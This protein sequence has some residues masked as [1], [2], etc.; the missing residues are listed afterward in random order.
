M[1]EKLQ[2]DQT[3]IM[4]K[5]SIRKKELVLLAAHSLNIDLESYFDSTIR[6]L[7]QNALYCQKEMGAG[8]IEAIEDAERELEHL[9]GGKKWGQTTYNSADLFDQ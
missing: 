9:W 3:R 2:D 5:T 4:V 1:T 7:I 8:N 6:Q